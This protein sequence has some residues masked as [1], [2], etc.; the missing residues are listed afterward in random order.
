MKNFNLSSFFLTI[1]LFLFSQFSFAGALKSDKYEGTITQNKTAKQAEIIAFKK[2]DPLSKP[3]STTIKYNSAYAKGMASKVFN[4]RFM[5]GGTQ[6]VVGSIASYLLFKGYQWIEGK[7]V[8]TQAST[9]NKVIYSNVEFYIANSSVS[10]RRC[11]SSNPAETAA[12]GLPANSEYWTYE[13][14]QVSWE[15]LNLSP[16]SY[17]VTAP[18]T[19]RSKVNSNVQENSMTIYYQIKNPNASLK[20]EVQTNYV[21]VNSE[22]LKKAIDNDA[23][24][25]VFPWDEVMEDPAVMP[26]IERALDNQVTGQIT[27]EVDPSTGN[28]SY[29]LSAACDW[30]STLCDWLDWTK[31]DPDESEGEEVDIDTPEYKDLDTGIF[32]TNEQCPPDL[33][34]T[35]TLL[36][37]HQLSFS[38]QNMCNAFTVARPVVVFIGFLIATF[39]LAGHRSSSE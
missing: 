30:F 2:K 8:D 3:V 14:G 36:E 18:Y 13:L 11:Q 32:S 29:K 21:Y 26:D 15:N 20:P 27:P 24:N 19:A 22:T 23:D 5:K 7:L 28:Q 34:L 37:S 16:N 17:Y 38:Y 25:P 9:V 4:N 1:F 33:V 35:Y 39:I 31:E 10:K 6:I 12:C